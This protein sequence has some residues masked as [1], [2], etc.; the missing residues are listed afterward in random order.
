[1]GLFDLFKKKSDPRR[2]LIDLLIYNTDI[3]ERTEKKSRGDAEYLAICLILD[4]LANRPNGRVGHQEMMNIIQESYP[5][6]FNDV[7][8]Y[9]AWSSGK[10]ILKREAEAA[11]RKRHSR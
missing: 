8:T 10:I 11:L 5:Q 3:I 2:G 1:M 6:H 4:D 9:L 7:I